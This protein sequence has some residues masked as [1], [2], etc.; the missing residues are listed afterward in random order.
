MGRYVRSVLR[1]LAARPEVALTLL[2]RDTQAAPDDYKLVGPVELATPAAVQARSRFDVV[3]YPW[4]AMRFN[5]AAPSVVTIN[6]DFAFRFPARGTVARWREQRPIRRAARAATHVLT[7]SNW[8]C[9]A[10]RARF[11]IAADR[12]SV[13][14]LG[15]DESFTPGV[16]ASPFGEPFVVAVGTV[17]RRKNVA[18]LIDAF[19]R[20]FPAGNVRLVLVGQLDTALRQHVQT[21]SFPLSEQV[22]VDDASLRR[23]YRTAAVVAVP[24][25]AEGFGLVAAEA[26]ACGA[27]VIAA[28]ASALPETV[29]SAGMLLAPTDA[30]AWIHALQSLVFDL[31]L[32]RAFAERSRSRWPAGSAQR[33][34]DA[35]LTALHGAVDDRA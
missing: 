23:L 33:T 6:D 24:S 12:I 31:P 20:A 26:Q 18:F 16:E 1:A 35:I 10:L 2:V 27:A 15:P 21:A 13:I 25:L 3:W 11:G 14:P 19:R 34:A 5:S 17:E 8:S 9:S 7:I 28:H 22:A 30:Q 32:R 29:G 4:N